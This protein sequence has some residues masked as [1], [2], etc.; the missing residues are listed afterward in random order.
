MDL[1]G[2]MMSRLFLLH[3]FELIKFLYV[4][5]DVIVSF[6]DIAVGCEATVPFRSTERIAFRYLTSQKYV[7]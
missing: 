5:G 4:Q 6:D 7:L 3:L 2:L 1:S